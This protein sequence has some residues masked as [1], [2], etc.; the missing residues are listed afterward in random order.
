V[1]Q[2][3]DMITLRAIATVKLNKIIL[4]LEQEVEKLKISRD[5]DSKTS[6]QPPSGDWYQGFQYLIIRELGI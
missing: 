1:E 6:S 2:L 3:A 5:L 4:E